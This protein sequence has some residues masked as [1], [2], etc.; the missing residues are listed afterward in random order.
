MNQP[1]DLARY[2][3]FSQIVSD[4]VISS[5]NGDF[6]ST[7]RLYGI[8]V[9]SR[10]E[11]TQAL[12]MNKLNT[13]IRTMGTGE[14]S[15]TTH[16]IP[17]KIQ[18]TLTIPKINNF[19]DNLL[20]K[21]YGITNEYLHTT[22]H[23]LT[24]IYRPQK[25]SG[26]LGFAF[27]L[28]N[29][30]ETRQKA[31]GILEEVGRIIRTN[32][33]EYRVT[34]LGK[35]EAEYRV[36][37]VEGE[38]ETSEPAKIQY[39]NSQAEFYGFLINS[40][41]QVVP[42]KMKSSLYKMLPTS[43]MVYGTFY[44]EALLPDGRRRYSYFIDIK[45]YDENT[46][47]GIIDALITLPY[48]FVETQIFVPMAKVDA[49]KSLNQIRGQLL[50]AEDDGLTQ[51]RDLDAAKEGVVNGSF[52]F[53]FYSYQIEIFGDTMEEA[54]EARQRVIRELGESG[55]LPANV[56]S[57]VN[58]AHYASWPCN[59]KHR[60]RTAHVSS[61][62]F[63]GMNSFHNYATGKK[64]YNPWGEA[65]IMLTTA[66][67]QP[68][69]LNL[70]ESPEGIDSTNKKTLGNTGIIGQAGTGKTVMTN[71]IVLSTFKYGTKSVY[72]DLD[73]GCEIGIR[74]YGGSYINIFRNE[75]SGLAP[76]KLEPTKRNIGFWKTIVKHCAKEGGYTLN[77]SE[78]HVIERAVTAVAQHPKHERGFA[79]LM[80]YLQNTD[81]NGVH[82]RMKKWCRGNELG[83]ALDNEQ[84]KLTFS[85]KSC[86]GI[87]CTELIDDK[88]VCPAIM[89]YLLYR[90]ASE[91]DGKPFM[92]IMEE[93]WK[94][95]ENN[96]FE[97][98]AKKGQKTIRKLN[99][100]GI[101]VTQQP[102]DALSTNISRTL[103]E[104][105][106][107]MIY[108]PN[109]SASEED[110][111]GGYKLTKLEF[112]IVKNLDPNSRL[113]LIKK[114]MTSTVVRL[115]LNG[116]DDELDVISGTKDNLEPME[117]ARREKGEDPDLWVP[118]YLN[119]V[120]KMRVKTGE[121]A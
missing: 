96:S 35:Y 53:G 31:V 93:F 113:M 83:W 37:N 4:S 29:Y 30:E 107:T 105:M 21:Y 46:Y 14:F 10:D 19:V 73:R 43:R 71:M 108:L 18:S 39:R 104:Q 38:N 91:I 48:E 52:V 65:I 5:R 11:L 88:E 67:G 58:H 27:K 51:I 76:F 117:Q 98:F 92:Y 23:Y 16:R 56:D 100:L 118:H 50:S 111:C 97:D 70:H 99:G 25:V 22:E 7:W 95:L 60:T 20:K 66:N 2:V 54:K 6:M 79:L 84:D 119:L 1:I 28:K 8:D 114:G 78:E 36:Q 12:E 121:F 102:S 41:W 103:I 68:Y 77:P 33:K 69:Y 40:D 75:N 81:P 49:L 116:M 85:Q 101:F 109:P 3:P 13:L 90:T 26:G 15:F 63:A 110:Y 61:R 89:L 59:F 74:A 9:T 80:Q 87:D 47:A 86:T 57:I 120:K 32:F 17:R 62:N 24:V 34:Q 64:H 82:A 94:L 44:K 115:S 72:F 55:F 45:D 106:A 112:E 42:H